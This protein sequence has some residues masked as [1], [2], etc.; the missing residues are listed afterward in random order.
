[1]CKKRSLSALRSH[2]NLVSSGVFPWRRKRFT[3]TTTATTVSNSTFLHINR[4]MAFWFPSV[5][6]MLLLGFW[7]FNS[8]LRMT[9]CFP[10][11]LWLL[12][13]SRHFQ[14]FNYFWIVWEWLTFL[15]ALG[16]LT[17]I[18]ALNFTCY[19]A[20]PLL[21][22]V[23]SRRQLCYCWSCRITPLLCTGH[24]VK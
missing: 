16:R 5:Q 15:Q 19:L 10:K 2:T 20:P 11:F 13:W 6:D 22:K 9:P 17:F 3:T 12:A 14:S 24:E 7:L 23:Q 21:Q 1:M 18:S 4:Q 8:I